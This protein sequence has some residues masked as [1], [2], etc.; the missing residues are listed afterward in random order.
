[1]S[2]ADFP[3][4]RQ[5]R[6]FSQK[7]KEETRFKLVRRSDTN[8]RREEGRFRDLNRLELRATRDF[9]S[10]RVLQSSGGAELVRR[11]IFLQAKRGADDNSSGYAVDVYIFGHIALLNLRCTPC[12]Y[13][14]RNLVTSF[15]DLTSSTDDVP[16]GIPVARCFP[17]CCLVLLQGE[18]FNISFEWQN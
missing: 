1:M 9:A 10:S 14:A 13:V 8:C 17:T 4:F 11:A 2:L 3:I 12:A 6:D 15:P 18:A 7:E 16:R 5:R